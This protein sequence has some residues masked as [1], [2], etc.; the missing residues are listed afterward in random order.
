MVVVGRIGGG[1]GGWWWWWYE[2]FSCVVAATE[3][4]THHTTQSPSLTVKQAENSLKIF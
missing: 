3:G 1:V 4:R 2:P